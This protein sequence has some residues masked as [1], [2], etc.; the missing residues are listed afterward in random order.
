VIVVHRLLKNTV[1]SN[2]YVLMTQAFYDLSGGFP[3]RT[4]EAR[5][6]E[7]EGFG[8]MAVQVYYKEGARPLPPR[9]VPTPPIPG[10][11]YGNTSI[12]WSA[13]AVARVLGRSRNNFSHLPDARLTLADLWEY[14]V[15]G[16]GGNLVTIGRYWLGQQK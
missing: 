6:E 12:R 3:G 4:P 1:P 7:C 10:T 9:P 14:F 16:L 11:A 15:T 2:E 13:Y 8:P 5:V